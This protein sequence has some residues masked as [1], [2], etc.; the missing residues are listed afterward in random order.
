MICTNSTPIIAD[1]N[2]NVN[3]LFVQFS[4][5]CEEFST[6]RK[7][8]WGSA[9]ILTFGTK[10]ASM[11]MYLFKNKNHKRVWKKYSK[12]TIWRSH[13]VDRLAINYN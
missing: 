1:K 9:S 8:R 3:T 4:W 2:A 6:E 10:C 11:K 7:A 12:Y 5:F 13:E